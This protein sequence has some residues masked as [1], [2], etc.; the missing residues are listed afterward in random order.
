MITGLPRIW[1]EIVQAGGVEDRSEGV[2][3]ELKRGAGEEA[4]RVVSDRTRHRPTLPY[5]CYPHS[6]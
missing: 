5:E 3:L 4:Q 2:S 1:L 6:A